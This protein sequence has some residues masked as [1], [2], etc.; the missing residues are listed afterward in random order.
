MAPKRN[1]SKQ[2][3]SS[4]ASQKDKGKAV[5]PDS[6]IPNFGPA[7]EQELEVAPDAFFEAER[8]VS[9]IT[10]QAKITK[11][12]LNHNIPLGKT[13]VI[14]RPAADGERSCTPLDESFAA[15]SGEHF[16][17]GAFLP[18][19]QYFADF[20]NYVGLAPFQLP[21]NSYR[22]LAGLKYLFQKHEWEVPTPAD[23]L[24]F[25]CL[26]ASPDQRGR[27]GGFYYLTRF[28]NTAAIIELLIDPKR[29]CLKIYTRKRTNRIYRIV[30]V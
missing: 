30:F 1:A 21:P 17:A 19:D 13:S 4:L 24:Y 9:K 5:M 14:A 16:K 10:S 22:L 29:V 26:K 23:I 8:I 28:P 15:W 11:I 2:T 12:F 27:G 3:V 25:F 18:L 6:P 7:V 20:L